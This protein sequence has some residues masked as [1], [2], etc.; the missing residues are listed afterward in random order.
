MVPNVESS[1]VRSSL[2]EDTHADL[3]RKMDELASLRMQVQLREAALHAK[4]TSRNRL[5]KLLPTKARAHSHRQYR[6][7]G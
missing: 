3:L 1:N 2:L 7:A 5:R 6:S 4:V